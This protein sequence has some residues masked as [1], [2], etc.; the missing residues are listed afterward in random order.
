LILTYKNEYGTIRM[1]GGGKDNAWCV[2]EITGIGFPKRNFTYN[3]YAGVYGQELASVSIPSRTITISGDISAKAQKALPMHLAAKI[4]NADGELSLQT[5]RKARRAKVRTL[6]FE[7]QERKMAYKTFVLQLESDNPYFWGPAPLSYSVFSRQN[8]LKSTFTLPC[9]F[10]R[11]NMSATVINNGDTECEPVLTIF[12]PEQSEV[13]ESDTLIIKNEANGAVITLNHIMQPGETVTV[14]IPNRTIVSDS[15]GSILQEIS[16]DT[17][18]SA[19]VLL[20]GKNQVSCVSGDA[21]L[22]VVCKFETLYLEA[23]HYE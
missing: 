7:V 12:K 2:T 22:A 18:L 10:S 5:G 21:S 20:T 17:V 16:D 13:L 6:S 8:L 19:F 1:A 14:D 3:T 15:S 23:S 4:L 9:V 11:R